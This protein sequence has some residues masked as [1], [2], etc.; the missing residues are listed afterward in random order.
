ME[1]G[2]TC[3]QGMA[4]IILE[5]DMAYFLRCKRF[6]FMLKYG[7]FGYDGTIEAEIFTKEGFPQSMKDSTVMPM[8]DGYFLCFGGAFPSHDWQ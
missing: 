8:S 2:H 5:K 7:K 4:Y 1:A 3:T 6:F